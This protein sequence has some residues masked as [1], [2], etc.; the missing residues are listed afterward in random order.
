MSYL[1]QPIDTSKL[2]ID[3]T[4]HLLLECLNCGADNSVRMKKGVEVIRAKSPTGWTR[5]AMEDPIAIGGNNSGYFQ[6][7]PNSESLFYHLDCEVCQC[8]ALQ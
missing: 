3:E 1:P 2:T 8:P 7:G 6:Q 5:D 4:Y